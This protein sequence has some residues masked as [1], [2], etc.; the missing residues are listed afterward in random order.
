[1]WRIIVVA[2]RTNRGSCW[3]RLL[4]ERLG[5]IYLY[6]GWRSDWRKG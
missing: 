1:M 3:T 4:A 6:V 5:Q 2:T